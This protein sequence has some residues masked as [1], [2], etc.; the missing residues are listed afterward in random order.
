M[1]ETPRVTLPESLDLRAAQPLRDQLLA[2]RGASVELDGSG[3]RRLGALGL[4]VLLAAERQWQADGQSLRLV[5]P[6][7]DLLAGLKLLG[8]AETQSFLTGA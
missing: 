8:V 2:T 3:V 5:D 1:S 6:S 4:Q 7:P